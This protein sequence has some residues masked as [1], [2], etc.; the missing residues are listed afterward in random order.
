MMYYWKEEETAKR[1]DAICKQKS[2]PGQSATDYY[3]AFQ[4]LAYKQKAKN[5]LRNIQLAQS[6][7]N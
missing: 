2:F 3:F 1:R 5:N 6:L 7:G 4:V